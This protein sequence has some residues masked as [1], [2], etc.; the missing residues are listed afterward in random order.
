VLRLLAGGHAYSLRWLD[1]VRFWRA[2]A[3]WWETLA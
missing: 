3:P 2:P 1:L